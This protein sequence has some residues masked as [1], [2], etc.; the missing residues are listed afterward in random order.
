VEVVVLA[1]MSAVWGKG[2]VRVVPLGGRKARKEEVVFV[3]AER[4][5]HDN[6]ELRDAR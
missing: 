2:R 6:D 3:S 4:Q 1:M 5:D